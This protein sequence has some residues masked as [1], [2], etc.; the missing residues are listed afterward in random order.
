[1]KENS[2]AKNDRLKAKKTIAYLFEDSNGFGKYPIRILWR[3]DDSSLESKPTKM[4]VAV[5]KRRVKKAAQRNR[6][7]RMIREVY[8]NN[9]TELNTFFEGKKIKCHLG[10]LYIGNPMV[11]FDSINTCLDELLKRLP[12]EYEKLTK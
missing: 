9:K 3:I 12:L 7:K 10:I 2:L 11:T 8:R 5:P 6:I 1:M 4:L